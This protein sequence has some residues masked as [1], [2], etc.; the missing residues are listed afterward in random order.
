MARGTVSPVNT[1]KIIF[2]NVATKEVLYSGSN[3]INGQVKKAREEK[4]GK[5][6]VDEEM[7]RLF[8]FVDEKLVGVS[9][10]AT[11]KPDKVVVFVDK[12]VEQ[13][14]PN[15]L[16][17]LAEIR[18]FRSKELITPEKMVEACGKVLGK[19][20]GE[21]VASGDPAAILGALDK[22]LPEKR[23]ESFAAGG[24]SGDDEGGEKKSG[25][26]GKLFGK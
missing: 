7:E 10:P 17:T 13:K 2:V 24:G 1:T 23:P 11:A 9:F 16:A 3:L 14:R 21:R 22:W 8:G 12:L 26:F 4:K 19:E 5:D 20:A 6:P 18:F 15:P 25:I